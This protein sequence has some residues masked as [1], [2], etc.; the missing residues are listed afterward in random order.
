MTVDR[1]RRAMKA[2]Y[3]RRT[4]V[5]AKAAAEGLTIGRMRASR[6]ASPPL[7]QAGGDGEEAGWDGPIFKA[8]KYPTTVFDLSGSRE[9]EI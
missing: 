8:M 3:R 4:P 2:G 7:C 9:R 1:T 5:G 6:D